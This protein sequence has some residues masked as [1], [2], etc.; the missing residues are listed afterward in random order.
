MISAYHVRA[1][2]GVVEFGVQIIV[3]RLVYP[4]LDES[5]GISSGLLIEYQNFRAIPVITVRWGHVPLKG[6]PM[7]TNDERDD[8][9][10]Q[11][12]ATFRLASL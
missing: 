11:L 9:P 2:D 1:E 7:E 8:L 5:T 4:V 6:E 12:Q 10:N 3:Y